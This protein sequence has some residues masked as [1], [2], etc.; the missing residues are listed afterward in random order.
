[1]KVKIALCQMY[2]TEPPEKNRETLKKQMAEAAALGADFF[3]VPEEW[4]TTLQDKA[5]EE[6]GTE[7]V[8]GPSYTVLQE[9]AKKYGYYVIGGSVPIYKEDRYTNTTFVFDREGNEIARYDK[10]HMFD[11][12]LSNG[13]EAKE[14][15]HVYPGGETCT[16]E[17]EFGTMGT[18]ICYDLRFAGQFVKMARDGARIIFLPA[19]FTFETGEKH[20]LNLCKARALDT[21]CFFVAVNTPYEEEL[22]I[23]SY[24]H[25]CVFDPWGEEVLVMDEK[26]GL[27][28]TEIDL[29]RVDEI[30]NRLPVLAGQRPDIY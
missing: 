21:Q 10:I 18:A 28:V 12:V 3:V 19:E 29:D 4:N 13:E 7:D 16:F 26:P 27:A 25:S 14:S 22:K 2:K 6:A 24:G 20:W 5:S 17:T 9:G 1:M 11:L 30:R 15:A 8:G 23:P